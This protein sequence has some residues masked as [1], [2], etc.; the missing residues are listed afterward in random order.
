[1]SG[2]SGPQSRS[3]KTRGQS[4][5]VAVA[6]LVLIAILTI[7]L[8][9]STLLLNGPKALG[10]TLQLPLHSTRQSRSPGSGKSIGAASRP[11]RLLAGPIL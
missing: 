8:F 4:T 5:L 10:G 1:M 2:F 3:A 6:L 7:P 9:R 11:Q